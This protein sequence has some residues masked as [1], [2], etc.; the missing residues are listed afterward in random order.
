MQLFQSNHYAAFDP[1]KPSMDDKPTIFERQQVRNIFL[2]L[3][4]T[5]WPFIERSGWDLHR[6]RQ[7]SHY[8]SSVMLSIN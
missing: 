6:H 5:L 8:V 2:K 4:D 3:D 7:K 1:P